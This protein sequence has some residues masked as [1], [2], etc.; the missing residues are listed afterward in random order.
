M[1][2][3]HHCVHVFLVLGTLHLRPPRRP[4]PLHSGQG[5]P[6]LSLWTL[7]VQGQRPLWVPAP[8]LRCG[9]WAWVVQL[10]R[11]PEVLPP[12]PPPARPRPTTPS[13]IL[14]QNILRPLSLP[15]HLSAG[16]PPALPPGAPAEVGVGHQGPGDPRPCS[17][18][19]PCPSWRRVPPTHS[20]G[21]AGS[22]PT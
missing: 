3:A 12:C 7:W 20:Q 1:A 11:Q 10:P 14:T 21:P 13:L 18:P 9:A 4:T 19:T 17:E 2:P 5:H 6:G 15:T 22:S 16:R 8:L